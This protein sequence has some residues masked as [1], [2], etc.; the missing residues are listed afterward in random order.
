MQLRVAT[1][2]SSFTEF[3]FL[4]YFSRLNFDYQNKYLLTL[5]G[6]VDGS[7]RF[8]ENKRYGFFPAVSVGYVLSEEDFMKDSKV[9]SFLKVRASYGTTGNVGIGNFQHLGLYGS[10]SY[11]NQP[12]LRPTQIPNPDL[13][14]R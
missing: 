5:S 9:F 14:W 2:T 6:R 1:G 10:G 3:S 8:G 7:S 13:G 11:N 12:G 4:S